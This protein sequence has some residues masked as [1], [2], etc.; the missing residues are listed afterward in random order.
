MGAQWI[1]GEKNNVVYELASARKLAC[2]PTPPLSTIMFARSSGEVLEPQ[3]ANKLSKIF[4][5]LLQHP[6]NDAKSFRNCGEFYVHV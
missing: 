3:L 1:H 6:R 2:D 5:E 4:E